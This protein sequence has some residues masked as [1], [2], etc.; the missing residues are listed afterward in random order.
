MV[1]YCTGDQTGIVSNAK[2]SC[3]TKTTIM[4]KTTLQVENKNAQ[5]LIDFLSLELEIDYRRDLQ[6]AVILMGE[7]YRLRTNSNQATTVIIIRKPDMIEID[8]VASG[9]KTGLISFDWGSEN[10]F[11]DKAFMLVEKFCRNNNCWFRELDT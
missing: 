6:D 11:I 1:P 5:E 2:R 4:R 7:E 8:L 10:A 3:T 9:G